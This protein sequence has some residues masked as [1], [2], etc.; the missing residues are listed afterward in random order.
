MVAKFSAAG[1]PGGTI[2]IMIPVLEAY[3]GFSPEMSSVI[4]TM[5]MLFDPFCTSANVLG[6]GL[7]AIVFEKIW[8]LIVLVEAKLT[9]NVAV[10]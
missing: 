4:M 2:I 9:E 7:F 10:N 3:L 5:Y 1:V 6:N 8:D